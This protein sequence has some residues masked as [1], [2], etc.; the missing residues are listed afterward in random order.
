[1]YVWISSK[2]CTCILF[3]SFCILSFSV[4]SYSLLNFSCCKRFS[5]NLFIQWTNV[6]SD[7][8]S[9]I[10]VGSTNRR[11]SIHPMQDAEVCIQKQEDKTFLE[12][13]YIDDDIG[14]FKLCTVIAVN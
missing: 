13:N 1:M 7:Y 9:T 4:H 5:Q 14:K 8:I 11:K 2:R 3:I 10:Q 6:D 12:K